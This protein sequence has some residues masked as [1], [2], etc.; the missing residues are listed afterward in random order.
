MCPSYGYKATFPRS[1]STAGQQAD[2]QQARLNFCLLP[3]WQGFLSP[4]PQGSLATQAQGTYKSL[5]AQVDS[6]SWERAA[7][8]PNSAISLIWVTIR[9]GG[10]FTQAERQQRYSPRPHQ[11][12]P[13]RFLTK[14]IHQDSRDLPP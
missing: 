1:L 11:R 14:D 3:V 8:P 10:E 4:P 9:G 2:I 6:G 5:R 13:P 7:P 12:Y